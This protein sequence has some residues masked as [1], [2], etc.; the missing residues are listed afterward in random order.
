MQSKYPIAEQCIRPKWLESDR[1]EERE[2]LKE[3]LQI[4]IDQRGGLCRLRLLSLSAF[5][6]Y[7][8]KNG[9]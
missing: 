5:G 3:N 8:C 1:I 7:C 9:T 4:A 6:R 2:T